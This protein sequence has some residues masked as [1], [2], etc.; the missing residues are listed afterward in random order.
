MT[1]R[2]HRS[3]I[4]YGKS[5]EQYQS[6]KRSTRKVINSTRQVD[7]S[8]RKTTNFTIQGNDKIRQEKT[9]TK[10]AIKEFRGFTY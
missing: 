2:I 1:L 5:E 9:L 8:T 4:I 7:N 3:I 10:E 6:G